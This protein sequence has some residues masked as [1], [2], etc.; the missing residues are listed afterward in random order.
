M[1]PEEKRK[2][3]NK[4]YYEAT[5]EKR[6]K[7]YE[8]NKETFIVKAKEYRTANK[9][10]ISQQRKEYREINK[11]KLN[12][13]VKNRRKNDNLFKLKMNLRNLVRNIIN[14]KGYKKITKTELILGCSFN[15]FK[16]HIESKFESWMNWDNYG[17]PKDGIFEPNKTWD[18]DHIVPIN[19]GVTETELMKLNHYTNIQPLCSY[20]NRFVK[21]ANS[22]VK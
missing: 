18:Y 11:D 2:Q 10:K 17:N 7:E 5:K 16:E 19:D 22:E 21:K 6:K 9:E 13:Y 15:D 3:Q 20:H 12:E 4:L 8:A 1:T 14:N